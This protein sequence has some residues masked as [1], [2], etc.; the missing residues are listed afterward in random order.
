MLKVKA[1]LFDVF[2]TVVD[3]RSGIANEVKKIANK[4]KIVIL[5]FFIKLHIFHGNSAPKLA[6]FTFFLD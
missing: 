5:D 4:N 3:W 2:G 6:H 1:L